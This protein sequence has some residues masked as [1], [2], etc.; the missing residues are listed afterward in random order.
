M[1][2]F[3]PIK[4]ASNDDSKSDEDILNQKMSERRYMRAKNSD[5]TSVHGQGEN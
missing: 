4:A 3:G 1:L 5:K 2:A